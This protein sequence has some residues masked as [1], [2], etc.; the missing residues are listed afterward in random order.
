MIRTISR[1]ALRV[2]ALALLLVTSGPVFADEAGCT[3]ARYKALGK[4]RKCQGRVDVT[5]DGAYV[6]GYLRCREKYAAAYDRMA[7]RFSGTTCEGPRFVDN[8]D[9]TVTDNL[10][11]LVWE[12]KTDDGGPHELFNRYGWSAD[13]E[14]DADGTIFSDLLAGM[15]SGCF[16]EH[17]DW[18][19]PTMDEL[20]TILHP[21]GCSSDPC[22]ADPLLLPMLSSPYVS[23]TEG[24]FWNS[25]IGFDDGDGYALPK[26]SGPWSYRVVRGGL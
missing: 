6:E 5:Q 16:A 7:G 25:G 19:V 15:N 4:Y 8:G 2:Y 1:T 21:A 14:L 13:D 12:S 22:V 17:C 11:R 23:A 10:T 20:Q 9:G 18:R 26:S 24:P 3:A